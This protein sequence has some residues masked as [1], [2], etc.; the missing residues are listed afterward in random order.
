MNVETARTD[1]PT[2]HDT[3][4]RNVKPISCKVEVPPLLC[5]RHNEALCL[6]CRPYFGQGVQGGH[7]PKISNISCRFLLCEAVSQT[8]YCCSLKVKI[9]GPQKS[10]LATPLH[11][12]SNWCR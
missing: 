8:K 5:Q 3:F 6:L 7:A 10:W 4:R 1:L 11:T 12:V 9:F 2:I